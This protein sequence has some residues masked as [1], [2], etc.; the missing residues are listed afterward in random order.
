METSEI[1]KNLVENCIKV[2]EISRQT[3]REEI[4][5]LIQTASDYEGD[6]DLYD[7]FKE[8]LMKKKDL[9]LDQVQKYVNDINL[10][11]KVDLKRESKIVE[12][13][14]VVITDKQKLFISVAL[15]KIQFNDETYHAISTQVPIY[16]AM[17]NL[18]T[19]DSF[20]INN[21][22]FTIKNIF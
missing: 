10:I 6:H 14:T 4:D 3:V 1:K 21:N 11:K 16:K 13:G 2:L 8:E 18:K 12:F 7:P 19:G 15:G 5:G 22:E 17:Q 20:S 9:L